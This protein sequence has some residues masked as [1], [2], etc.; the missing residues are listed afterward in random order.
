MEKERNQGTL[1][2]TGQGKET[3]FYSDSGGESGGFIKGKRHS[4]S[5]V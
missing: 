5:Y 2:L 3:E 1:G 4:M